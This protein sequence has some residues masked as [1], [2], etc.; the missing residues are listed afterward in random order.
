MSQSTG[1]GGYTSPSSINPLIGTSILSS[2]S[3]GRSY[4]G[5]QKFERPETNGFSKTAAEAVEEDIEEL[6]DDMTEMKIKMAYLEAE[7]YGMMNKQKEPEKEPCM[8]IMDIY[9]V[10]EDMMEMDGEMAN[11]HEGKMPREMKGFKGDIK[12]DPMMDEICVPA[13]HTIEV[14][15]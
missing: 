10:N 1:Q 12:I 11:S 15:A 5:G 14:H 2:R 6:E 8:P 9:M 4:G 3:S 7:V 13:G